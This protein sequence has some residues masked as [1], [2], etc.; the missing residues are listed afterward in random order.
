[1]TG[2]VAGA[3]AVA[4]GICLS[5][6]VGSFPLDNPAA[7]R[8]LRWLLL[9]TG[10]WG[11]CQAGALYVASPQLTELLYIIGLV[12]GLSTVGAWLYF[13]SAYTGAS[14]HTRRDTRLVAVT[15]Y[16][17]FVSLKLTNPF[18][19]LY[20]D[21]V[22]DATAPLG[23]VIRF[24][25]LYWIAFAVAYAGT[26]I[27]FYLLY[28]AFRESP[29]ATTPLA[30]FVAVTGLTVV[31]KLVAGVAPAAVP[32]LSY[33][34]IGVA[35]FALGTRYL[36]DGTFRDVEQAAQRQLLTNTDDGVVI[37]DPDGGVRNYNST[38]AEMFPALRDS[39]PPDGL[40]DETLDRLRSG[41]D[42]HELTVSRGS[43][44]R[45]YTATS[46]PL[47][48]GEELSGYVLT[49][50][51][52]TQLKQQRA[53]RLRFERAVEAID[54][55]VFI[56]AT[57]GTVEYVNPAF[58]RTTGYRREAAVDESLDMLRPATTETEQFDQMLD[59]VRT[60]QRWSGEVACRRKNGQTYTARQTIAPIRTD[61][62]VE[63][64]IGVQRDVT[65]ERH[66]EQQLKV[67]DRVL[68]HNVRNEL[69][70]IR[71]YAA[72]IRAD[73]AVAP[74]AAETIID[75]SQ[76]LLGT[77]EKAR[78]LSEVL[79][80]EPPTQ[81]HRLKSLL[82]DLR[83]DIDDEY[84]EATLSVACPNGV[85]VL[86]TPMIEK[87]LRELV[88]NAIIHDDSAHPTVEITVTPKSAT[89]DVRVTDT[90]PP[91]PDVERRVVHGEQDRTA[92]HHGAGLGLW[93]VTVI[94]SQ[95]GGDI[96]FRRKTD[97]G[98]IVTLT[99]PSPSSDEGV[100]TEA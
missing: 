63:G 45:Y 61:D 2:I 57:D 36:V 56:V 32:P 66:R 31:P 85:T 80:N 59:S 50:R 67:T 81:S 77:V 29:Y 47:T 93:L 14:Y 62:D 74:D 96:A 27:G 54:Q 88:V 5:A 33:E 6:V 4:G 25:V 65:D 97:R 75:R 39:P 18:H 89:V 95:S 43:E 35:V 28:D 13:C 82:G 87:A 98:N 60:Q 70:M 68:R 15:V 76:K 86:A 41:N 17:G 23:H 92:V 58:E 8:G 83:A 44:T 90:A 64:V 11:L 48:V 46:E 24:D 21:V 34:P 49:L 1:M 69:N 30:V 94:V 53:K 16:V 84:P 19:G 9:T 71:G 20:L 73:T 100:K 51:D 38:A 72:Q 40:F 3:F 79:T 42:R 37:T 78:T 91:I 55:A 10:I 7:N 52:T 22:P 26:A 12:I 99:F